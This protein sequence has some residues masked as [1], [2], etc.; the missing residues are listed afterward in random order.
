MSRLLS[1]QVSGHKESNSFCLNCL[2][3]FPNEEKLKIHEEYCLKNQAIR[4][5]MPEKGSFIS[6][7][8]HNRSIKVPFVVY[9][10]FEAFTEEIL[11]SKQNEKFSF[12]QKYQKHKPSGF[13][14]KIV[15][16]DEQ[17]FNK[18]PVLFRA[19][20]NVSAIFVEMLERDIKRIQEKFDF[21]KKMIFSF[22]DKDDFEKAKICWIC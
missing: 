16:F 6:F 1:R 15:C 5:E 13:C 18:K 22:K 19:R 12:T 8:H 11:I 7:I 20:K 3:H 14:Y 2:N 9:A 4:I 10:D 17:L 21:S